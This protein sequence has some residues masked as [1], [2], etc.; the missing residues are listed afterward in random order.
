MFNGILSLL[1][2]QLISICKDASRQRIY[3]KKKDQEQ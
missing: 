3:L 2:A 1:N